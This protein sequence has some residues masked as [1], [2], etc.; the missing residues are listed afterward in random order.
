MNTH[1]KPKSG[2]LP[3]V[4]LFFITS[5]TGQTTSSIHFFS[6]YNV[7]QKPITSIDNAYLF[8]GAKA[9]GVTLPSVAATFFH[10]KQNKGFMKFSFANYAL[11][12][13]YF[14]QQNKM[15][16]IVNTTR[17][18]ADLTYNWNLNFIKFV[19]NKNVKISLGV[20]LTGSWDKSK[21]ST[22]DFQRNVY[23]RVHLGVVP[24]V[25]PRFQYFLNDRTFLEAEIPLRNLWLSMLYDKNTNKESIDVRWRSVS[26][27]QYSFNP[28]PRFLHLGIG[29]QYGK[30]KAKKKKT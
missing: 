9:I 5:M 26:T 18:A 16:G 24:V 25:V 15:N 7:F 13:D 30:M 3:L 20:G 12:K 22:A 29:Y 4:F 17:F 8:D 19:G 2:F 11:Q 1:L 14:I 28:A 27:M 10:Q 23:Q 21:T 6:G